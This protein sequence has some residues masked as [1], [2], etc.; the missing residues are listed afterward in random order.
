[1]RIQRNG[2][3]W[4]TAGMWAIFATFFA[5]DAGFSQ[6]KAFTDIT[7]QA[8]VR[9]RHHK[10]VLDEKLDNIMPWMASVGA[11][12]AAVDYDND[13][14][15]DLYVTN[16]QRG[17]PNALYR[18]NG[19]MTFTDVAEKAGVAWVNE[20]KGTSMDAVFGDYD[21]DGDLDL[22]S[23]KWGCNR[24]FRNNGDGTFTDVTEESGTGDC[25]NGNGAVW[26]DY[27]NDTY[28]DIVVGNY[29]RYVDLWRLENTRVMHCDFEQA[30]DAGPNVLYK[31]NGDGTF[32]NVAFELGVA[33]SG[34]TL[35]IGCAD[36]DN[37]GD[38]DICDANDFGQDRFYR[39]NGD[40]SFSNVTDDVLGWDTRKGM[41]VDF[42]DYNNDGWLDL[43]ISNVWTEEYLQEGNMLYRNMGDGTFADVAV[44][45]ETYD[46]GWSWGAKFFDFDNDGDLDIYV[47]N[48]FVSG[49]DKD[50]DKY[51]IDLA[52]AVTRPGFDPTEATNWPTM[53]DK[54]LS[55][56][57]ESRFFRNEG[58]EIFTEVAAELGVND[59]RD[60]RGIALADFD[61]DGDLDMFITNQGQDAILYRNDV[62]NKNNWL[63]LKLIGTVSNRNA[64][65]ARVRVLSGDLSQIRE[66]DGG[67]GNHSQS[68]Y[69]LHFGL[70]Q[71]EAI[72]LVEIRWPSGAVQKL[73]D[74]AIN[75]ILAVT[76]RE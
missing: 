3:R 24:L 57:E 8:G 76:E 35:D 13:G 59:R 40:G 32:T 63:E 33:D 25:G 42:G 60:G 16:S 7:D 68:S 1:M 6:Q 73:T 10:P 72:D 29:F 19:D 22:Y 36:Y 39:N 12:A 15:I 18:N 49:K 65:G 64:I 55:G 41:N 31:N 66:V 23:V 70:G 51:W 75:Q 17:H 11:A 27:N 5:V 37:D 56:Y 48:G 58:N 21:N 38:Q 28:L 50:K 30:R 43:Y 9:H 61:N 54:T 74:V 69:R 34:W 4:I 14:D 67:N 71:R 46:G 44:E 52:T 26:L 2:S 53:G 62:G 45:T 47:V 20:E